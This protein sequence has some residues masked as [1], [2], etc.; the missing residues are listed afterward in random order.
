MG[1]GRLSVLSVSLLN[2]NVGIM[3]T[4]PI[5]T[6]FTIRTRTILNGAGSF[7]P[8]CI[9]HILSSSIFDWFA[10]VRCA[11]EDGVCVYV[12]VCHPYGFSLWPV[13]HFLWFY[14]IFFSSPVSNFK[15]FK[16][17]RSVRHNFYYL[18]PYRICTIFSWFDGAATI[19]LHTIIVIVIAFLAML[20]IFLKSQYSRSSSVFIR[21]F[22]DIFISEHLNR[23]L[24]RR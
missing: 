21:I 13:L 4:E 1:Y 20:F 15:H 23:M 5:S 17:I 22:E 12:W 16:H 14:A 24:A 18:P 8:I 7:W 11:F 2:V 3:S 6:Y 9:R 19:V 10:F